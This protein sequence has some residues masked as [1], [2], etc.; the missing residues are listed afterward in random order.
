VIRSVGGLVAAAT[1][2]L[3][4]ES[5]PAAAASTAQVWGACGT[6]TA[7]DKAVRVFPSPQGPLTLRCGG[8]RWSDSPAWGYRHLLSRHVSDFGGS[9]AGTFQNW[10]DI[11]DLA[12]ETVAADPDALVPA[13]GDQTCRSRVLF[14]VNVQT[15]QVARQQIFVMYTQ[16]SSNNIVT[17]FPRHRQCAGAE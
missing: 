2:V 3:S 13:R 5:G 6:M 15:N 7:E 8:P 9:A 11:A 10:R 4:A 17:V 12:M 14:L 1:L 16:N